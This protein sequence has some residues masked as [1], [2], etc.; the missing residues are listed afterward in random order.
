[1]CITIPD[2]LKLEMLT[3]GCLMCF[4]DKALHHYITLCFDVGHTSSHFL[5][6]IITTC[7]FVGQS[8]ITCR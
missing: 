8:Y 4:E 6:Q 1:M 3:C 2:E 5:Q 7:I